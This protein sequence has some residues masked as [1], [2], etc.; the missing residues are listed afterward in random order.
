MDSISS[1]TIVI[2][3]NTI[4]TYYILLPNDSEQDVINDINI[5]GEY[6]SLNNTFHTQQGFQ[7]FMKLINSYPDKLKDVR[8]KTS[9]NESL[10]ITEFL[11]VIT[12]YSIV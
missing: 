3:V 7:V 6:Q 11:D 2:L 4:M 8:I 1:I 10:T 12:G 5:L 9:S